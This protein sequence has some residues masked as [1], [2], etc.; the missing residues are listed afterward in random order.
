MDIY[1]CGPSP[2]TVSLA[3]EGNRH[4]FARAWRDEALIV[5]GELFIQPDMILC[6]ACYEDTRRLGS[7]AVKVTLRNSNLIHADSSLGVDEVLSYAV[8]L[9]LRNN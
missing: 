9:G 5:L 6:Y 1:F 4:D 7:K 3:Q 8:S 2:K